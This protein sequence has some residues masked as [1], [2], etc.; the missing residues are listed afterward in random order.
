MKSPPAGRRLA[1]ARPAG[2]TAGMQER[3]DYADPGPTSFRERSPLLQLTI[4]AAIL[5]LA[6]PLALG[7]VFIVATALGV[8]DEC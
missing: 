2:H 1:P 5:I 4:I 6:V 7:A 3:E 8:G